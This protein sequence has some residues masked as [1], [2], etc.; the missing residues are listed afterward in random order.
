MPSK[1]LELKQVTNDWVI[2]EDDVVYSGY[3]AAAKS[4]ELQIELPASV[5]KDET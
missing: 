3:W 1:S 5:C 4:L 2:I